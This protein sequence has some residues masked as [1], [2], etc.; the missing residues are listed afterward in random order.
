MAIL[1]QEK[2]ELKQEIARL[3]GEL[4][5]IQS[6]YDLLL[7]SAGAYFVIFDDTKILEFSP[8]SEDIFVHSNDFAHKYIEEL[9]PLFQPNGVATKEVW[10][11]KVY[12]AKKGKNE[13]FELE[14]LD[15]SGNTFIATASIKAL[16]NESYILTIDLVEES[17]N[18]KNT[19]QAIADNAPVLLRMTDSNNYFNYFSKQWLK[20]TGNSEEQ[21]ANN[22][23]LKNIHPTDKDET[24]RVV[25][26]AFKKKKK[27]EVSFRIKSSTG[28]Y[29]WLLDTGIPRDSKDGKFIGYVAAAID[30]TER[31]SIELETT[32]QKA[33]VESE[34]KIQNSLNKSEIIA[35]T[36]NP[37]GT[38][39]FCNREFLKTLSIQSTQLTG[40][41][42]F[43]LFSPDPAL[44]INRKKY[45]QMARH[46]NFS[47]ALSGKFSTEKG[48]EVVIRFNAIILKDARGMVSGITLFGENITERRKVLKELERTNNQLKELFDN[49]YDLIQ[50]FNE[51]WQ[52]QFVNVAWKEKLGFSDTEI[53]ELT[54][55]KLVN[56]DYWNQ[57]RA[58][59]ISISKG[60]RIDRFETVFVSKQGKNMYVS[61][62]VNCTIGPGKDQIQ[63]RGVF[64]DITERIRAE[65][66]QSLYFKVADLTTSGSNLDNLYSSIYSE[67]NDILRIRNF[68]VA[69]RDG[70]SKNARINFPYFINEHESQEEIKEQMGVSTL[71]ANYTF[72]RKKPLIIYQDG[73]LKIAELK[74]SKLPDTLPKIWLGVQ[75]NM[76]NQP[77]GV[78]SIHSYID[79]A[80]FNHKDLELLHFI[81]SQVSMAMERKFN[82]DKIKDQ[83]ARLNAIFESSSHQMWSMDKD[84]ELTSFNKN[85][86]E[87]LGS[88]YDAEAM[89]GP[90][91]KVEKKKFPVHIAEYWNKKYK[92]AFEGKTINFETNIKDKTGNYVWRDVFMNPIYHTEGHIEEV[93]VIAN[94]ITEKKKAELGLVESEEKFRDIFESFQDIY[95]RCDLKGQLLMVSPSMEELVNQKTKKIL[96]NNIL[97]YLRSE[98]NLKQILEKLYE[99]K[100][101]RNFE[102]TLKSKNTNGLKFL[103]NVRL[104]NRMGKPVAIEGVA[105]DITQIKE[106]Q[107]EQIKA[108][109]MAEKSLE[110]KERFLA[111]MSHE[112]RTPMNGIVGMIDLMGS[113]ELNSEQFGYVKTIKKSS[114]TLM[115]IL[116]DILDLSKIEAGKMELKE[117]PVKTIAI[118]EKLYDLYSQQAYSNNTCLYYHLNKNLP[119]VVLIDETRLLQVLSNLTSNAIKF[120]EGKGTINISLRLQETADKRYR[121]KA[122]IKDEGIGIAKDDMLS[123]FQ[124]FNQLDNSSTKNYS[125]T[126]LGLAISKE[127]V[128]SMGGEIG[129]AS[130]PGLGSTFWF[131]FEA[132]IA[133]S[134]DQNKISDPAH[135][136][137]TKQFV[138]SSPSILIVDDNNVNRTVAAQILIKSGCHVDLATGGVEAIEK[139]KQNQ[140]DLIFMDIQMPEM[141]GVKATAIIKSLDIDPLPPIVAMTA[142]SMEED[143]SKFLSQ[144]LDD[145]MAKPLK[146]SVL[147]N[148]VKEYISFEPVVVEPDVFAEEPKELIINQN[149]LN[150][151]FKYGGHELISSVLADFEKE[152]GEQISNC[153]GFLEADNIEEIRK[154]LHTLKGSSGTLGIERLT[155]HTTNLEAQL[156][157]SNTKQLKKQLLKIQNS[158][159]EFQENYKNIIEN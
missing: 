136:K 38:I 109:E 104:I 44:N 152:A 129:V 97:R 63:Y 40:Q 45:A 113:T 25:D 39:T 64:Y 20:F 101:V 137:I 92:K 87:A 47:G 127:L 61:G 6:K 115:D 126:G 24:L 146:A 48:D 67:L 94:D 150:Q 3:K 62:R 33:I 19:I 36:T 96:Q 69:I 108:K 9:M 2:S 157:K 102:A 145:Y 124:N 74:K 75:I 50:I 84:L 71:L 53:Q 30:I 114:E 28:Q 116:N 51:E 132:G 49:S 59:L 76:S 66:A 72:E 133:T 42:L 106:A 56:P 31:K 118:F 18:L 35:L 98:G 158:F 88:Y 57:T 151:L 68:S 139:V 85:Y 90:E 55:E 123:L 7:E 112:I 10:A 95:F 4:K 148:K 110:V 12:D 79:R 46:G 140:Y 142:Y 29:R 107:E 41:N 17:E 16:E 100:S 89:I 121:F 117:R 149:T 11:D 32:R 58:N 120:S 70:R 130:T 105:R 80:A 15:K 81:S 134:E 37:E 131:T 34:K 65:K 103:C 1:N 43:D 21:E 86:A 93:S 52:F 78:I 77:I 153:F 154:E 83:T 8:K 27:Y 125:G 60:D 122:Q 91:F 119:D 82:M 26:L 54:L 13:S 14:A 99:E 111:N 23:W 155:K 73:I 5:S 147:I 128:K 143:R 141:D 138:D 156:K 159:Q 135:E 22:G 144:G